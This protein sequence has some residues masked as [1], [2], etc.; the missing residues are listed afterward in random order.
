MGQWALQVACAQ[1]VELI[2]QGL[3]PARMAVNVSMEQFKNHAFF[4]A[5][6][7]T[8]QSTGLKGSRLELEITESVSVLG[9]HSVKEQLDQLQAQQIAIAIDDFGTG[10]SSLS[11]LEQ[12][13]LDRLKVDK[14][15]VRQL[16]AAGSPRIAEIVVELGNTLGLRVLAEGIEDRA[17]WDTLQAMGCHEGQGFFIAR[18]MAQEQ[19]LP[20]IRHYNASLSLK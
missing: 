15:F 20:W 17:A 5:V 14:A 19:L 16:G 7:Q 6:L 3:A 4:S 10:Y 11:Y 2:A 18:P 13:P 9:S 8:L 12:L 1:M